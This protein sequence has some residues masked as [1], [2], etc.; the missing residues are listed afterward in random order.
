[1]ACRVP[2]IA[3]R[4]GGVP[5]LI[6]DGVNGFLF[7]V[8]DVEGMAGAAIALLSDTSRFEAMRDAARKTA[9]KHF[10]ASQIIPHYERYYAQVIEAS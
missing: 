10:C 9:Q 6:H 8:G 2:T 3:T 5:E 1:M 7:S 4:V